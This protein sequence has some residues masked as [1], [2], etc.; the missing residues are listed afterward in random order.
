MATARRRS[1]NYHTLPHFETEAQHV[2]SSFCC[3][4][5]TVDCGVLCLVPPGSACVRKTP[6]PVSAMVAG[7]RRHSTCI[8]IFKLRLSFVCGLPLG[9]VYT[10]IA[11][12]RGCASLSAPHLSPLSLSSPLCHSLF[13]YSVCPFGFEF[14]CQ[15]ALLSLTCVPQRVAQVRCKVANTYPSFRCHSTDFQTR[16]IA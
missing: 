15:P 7:C 8:C 3:L 10:R 1:K 6:A 12:R 13:R 9:C 14:L 4:L 5:P 11:D 2:V 16:I